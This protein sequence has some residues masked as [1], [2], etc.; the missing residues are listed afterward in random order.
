MRSADKMV[1]GHL[2]ELLAALSAFSE[3]KKYLLQKE[4]LVEMLIADLTAMDVSTCSLDKTQ[5]S[6]AQQHRMLI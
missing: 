6:E 1:R 5:T 4:D 2:F 3:G